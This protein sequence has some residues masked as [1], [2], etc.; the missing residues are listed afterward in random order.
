MKIIEPDRRVDL[1]KEAAAVT[2]FNNT[3]RVPTG[4]YKNFRVDFLGRDSGETRKFYS[5]NDFEKSVLVK[6]GSFIHVSFDLKLGQKIDVQ[7]ADLTV[8]RDSRQFL[9]DSLTLEV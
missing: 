2:F 7:K 3:G 4:S 5:K 8:D 9:S 6:K 1:S